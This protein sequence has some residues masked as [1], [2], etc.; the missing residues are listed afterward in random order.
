ME[1]ESLRQT[2]RER[3]RERQREGAKAPQAHV[4][5][6]RFTP[7]TAHNRSQ[8]NMALKED[9]HKQQLKIVLWFSL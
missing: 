1:Y 7:H 3:L 2:E 8:T 9:Q 6:L 5:A 4:S